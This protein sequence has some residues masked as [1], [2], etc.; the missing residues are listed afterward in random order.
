MWFRRELCV[1][2]ATCA[3]IPAACPQTASRSVPAG[4]QGSVTDRQIELPIAQWLAQGERSEIPWK[5]TLPRPAPTFRL[6]NVLTVTAEVNSNFLQKQG[7][8]HDLHFIVKVAYAKGNWDDGESHRSFRTEQGISGNLKMRASVYLKPGAYTVAVIL[9][10][11]VTE[12]RNLSFRHIQ[13]AGSHSG[14]VPELL[15]GV[16]DVSFAASEENVGPLGPGRAPLSVE[17][18]RP[19]LF[20]LIIDLSTR[21]QSTERLELTPPDMDASRGG[22]P[23]SP[24]P[25]VESPPSIRHRQTRKGTGRASEQTAEQFELQE[26]AKTLARMDFQPGCG[27]VTA[28]DVLRLRTLLPPTPAT[29]VDWRQLGQEN[30]TPD[31]VVVS[32]A[33]L[34]GRKE[35]GPFFKEQMG[36]AMEHPPECNLNSSNPLHVIAILSHG[37]HFPS[38][39]K[40]VKMEPGCN[41]RIFYFYETN[42]EINGPDELGKMLAPLSARVLEFENPEKFRERVFEFAEAVKKIP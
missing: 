20:D 16:A 2:V 24:E 38:G 27:R 19:I 4:P 33:S 6:I 41:C 42:H 37:I 22:L 11:A 14:Q 1:T 18:Q 31:K 9:Y 12:R 3:F 17:T 23:S 30:S 8:Q 26:I 29:E 28:L 32:V 40:K 34:S 25:G 5:L 35:A 39:S 21:E 10:D 15:N 13:V 36:Q 7:E